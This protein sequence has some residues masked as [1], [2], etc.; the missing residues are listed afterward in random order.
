[1]KIGTKV[2]MVNCLEAEEHKGQ[3]WVTRSE[4]WEMCGSMVVLLEGKR[5]GFDVSRLEV[6]KEKSE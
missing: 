3:I 2:R 6:V 4:P 5:G 1:M